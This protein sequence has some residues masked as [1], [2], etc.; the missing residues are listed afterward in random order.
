[1]LHPL[2]VRRGMEAE[3]VCDGLEPPEIRKDQCLPRYLLA[4]C[5]ISQRRKPYSGIVSSAAFARSFA[6]RRRIP[7]IGPSGKSGVAWGQ[8]D[9]VEN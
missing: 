6:D 2:C 7:E 4:L 8:R 9:E 1:M 3:N 5:F